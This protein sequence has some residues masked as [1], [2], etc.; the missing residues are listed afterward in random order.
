[1]KCSSKFHYF[2]PCWCGKNKQPMG[3]S[4]WWNLHTTRVLKRAHETTS[5]PERWIKLNYLGQ[6]NVWAPRLWWGT[7]DFWEKLLSL[8]HRLVPP[9]ALTRP[10][11]P[12]PRCRGCC[13]AP[14]WSL[15]S[16]EDQ[17]IPPCTRRSPL[18]MAVW[19]SLGQPDAHGD[20]INVSLSNWSIQLM[21]L[22]YMNFLIK[23]LAKIF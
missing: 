23:L 16:H 22:V 15:G 14:V 11:A 19:P 13:S 7:H 2:P 9:A 17:S 10:H 1:M 20:I 8:R 21:S 18:E 6:E 5:P 12:V 4:I 3:N